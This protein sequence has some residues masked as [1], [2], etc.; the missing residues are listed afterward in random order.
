MEAEESVTRNEMARDKCIYNR[1]VE[2][3]NCELCD[4][5]KK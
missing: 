1:H 3:T 4:R 5:Y 2:C